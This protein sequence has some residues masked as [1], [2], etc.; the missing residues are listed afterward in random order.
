MTRLR[1]I[2][3]VC[4]CWATGA[5]TVAWPAEPALPVSAATGVTPAGPSRER[6]AGDDEAPAA[7]PPGWRAAL[8]RLRAERWRG[9]D[10][11]HAV[12]Q[13]LTPVPEA[14]TGL[15]AAQW[16]RLVWR[17]Q[18]WVAARSGLEAATATALAQLAQ[19]R[20]DLPEGVVLADEVLVR[21]W[22]DEQLARPMADPAAVRRAAELHE[23]QCR[24]PALT[25]CDVDAGWWLLHLLAVHAERAGQWVEARQFEQRAGAL[26]M[27][28]GEPS[29]QAWSLSALAVVCAQLGETPAA[30]QAL[31]DADRMARRHA[32]PETT[33]RVRLNEARLAAVLGDS[34]RHRAALEEAWALARKIGRPRLMALLQANL[35]DL[36]RLTGHIDAGLRAVAQ[37]LPVL[38]RHRDL[39]A[40]PLLLHNGGLLRLA[41]G[42]LARGRSDLEAAR[43]L[44]QASSSTGL[45]LAAL[46]EASDALAAAGDPRAALALYHQA[47]ALRA[48][49]DRANQ[50]TITGQL[51]QAQQT[52]AARE[53]LVL[54]ARDTELK[55]AQLRT[56]AQQHRIWGLTLV[57]LLIMATVVAMLIRRSRETTRQLR[58]SQ[59]LLRLQAER[60]PLTGLA[61]RRRLREV[62]ATRGDA[63][64][65]AGA[66]LLLDLDHFK[67]INDEYGHNCGDQVLV[68]VAR[69]LCAG[70]RGDDLVCRWGGEE[71]LIF[72]PDL[73][74]SVLDAL[75]ERLLHRIG[76][77]PVVLDDG[78]ALAVTTSL[79]YASFPL[80]VARLPL[81]WEQAV[82]LVDLALY[83][84]KS[85]GRDRAVGLEEVSAT[86]ALALAEISDDFELAR[87]AGE[88]RLQVSVR[89]GH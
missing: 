73:G 17:T 48:G 57:M 45:L 49:I 55:N 1:L 69:R 85:M 65:L 46:E 4:V 67:Q 89:A 79:G 66:L 12:L 14:P 11:P 80:P 35:S 72:A 75:A 42:Q 20:G 31:A 59:A 70:V 47:Q 2:R 30:R 50:D 56:E 63:G 81:H 16:Q 9:E 64:G 33:L 68:E 29:L 8:Q 51:R 36:W 28:A 23:R 43:K 71:F 44:W 61:N 26:A 3:A 40:Q 19:L 41:Q 60:D 6:Q 15:P 34:A 54:L 37:A 76:D 88:V 77:E 84:A 22:A 25:G 74:G 58:S 87:L 62:L 38:E 24:P 32:D 83:T 27:Q 53:E 39:R 52:E 86:D 10:Q 21:A 78:R 82:N 18:G 13:A 7:V 5:G